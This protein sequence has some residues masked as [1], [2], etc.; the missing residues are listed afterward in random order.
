M[1][2]KPVGI[3]Q[4]ITLTCMHACNFESCNRGGYWRGKISAGCGFK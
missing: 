1:F 2:L 3:Y 4:R